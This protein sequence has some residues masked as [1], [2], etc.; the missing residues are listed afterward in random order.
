M[1]L[2]ATQTRRQIIGSALGVIGAGIAGA[3]VGVSARASGL[4]SPLSAIDATAGGT[5]AAA[6]E[7]A[8][9]V[10]V[11]PAV[12]DTVSVDDAVRTVTFPVDVTGG[13]LVMPNGFGGDSVTR[14]SGRHNGVDIGNGANCGSGAGRP[15]LACTD[16]RYV[17]TSYGGGSY[18]LKITLADGLGNYFHYHHMQ[19]VAEGL[20][21]GDDVQAGQVVGFMGSSGNT[22]WAHLH[23][24]VWV[25]GL[26][27]QQGGEAVDPEPWLP[28]P[29]EGVTVGSYSCD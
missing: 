1:T 6:T 25:G 13:K 28:L 19:S 21:V 11:G 22:Q 10:A 2:H 18:G 23:F 27:P 17:D 7:R 26:S 8:V 12:P 24:E 4:T 20:E 15:L 5:G 3:A 9:R 16:G 14:G 29:I